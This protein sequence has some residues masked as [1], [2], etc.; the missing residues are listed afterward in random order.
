MTKQ[1]LIENNFKHIATNNNQ[2]ELWA[3]YMKIESEDKVRYVIYFPQ[4]DGTG[5]DRIVSYHN[6]IEPYA[7]LKDYFVREI[8]NIEMWKKIN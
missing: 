7:I 2:T 8:R 5:E 6:T 3:K 4:V 1:D